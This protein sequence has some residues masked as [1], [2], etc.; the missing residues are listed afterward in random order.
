MEHVKILFPEFREAVKDKEGIVLLGCGGPLEDWT[1]GVTKLLADTFII[2]SVEP[3][4]T[5]SDFYRLETTGHRV[6]VAMVFRKDAKMEIGRMAVWRLTFG[7]CSWISD[8]LDNYASQHGDFG[9]VTLDDAEV[10]SQENHD[11]DDEEE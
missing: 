2:P 11:L 3:S 5:F 6:D 1:N 7:D 4:D 10:E 9:A 8:Y